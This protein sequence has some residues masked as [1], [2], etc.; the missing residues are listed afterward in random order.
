MSKE[1]E[2]REEML[3]A[4]T[5]AAASSPTT[6]QEPCAKCGYRDNS[7]EEWCICGVGIE[8]L[9]DNLLEALRLKNQQTGTE[10]YAGKTDR[11][12]NFT[13]ARNAILS[14]FAALSA[15]RDA[16]IEK[17]NK[18]YQLANEAI[19]GIDADRKQA[20]ADIFALRE[21]NSTLQREL[22]QWKGL[23]ESFSKTLNKLAAS[24]LNSEN[25]TLRSEV[26]RLTRVVEAAQRLCQHKHVGGGDST[27]VSRADFLTLQ[28]VLAADSPL[29]RNQ[30]RGI[31]MKRRIAIVF[32][33]ERWFVRRICVHDLLKDE[34]IYRCDKP[35]GKSYATLADVPQVKALRR[36]QTGE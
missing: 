31:R 2:T 4:F 30:T 34:I 6:R 7:P 36:N 12:D 26:E 11:D 15:E 8:K 29:P 25:T 9:L 33:G 35:I 18:T 27:Y 14:A 1:F 32:D 28:K 24:D 10:G 19:E 23:A 13:A 21:S 3:A 5:P 20:L 22:E 17:A 16:A